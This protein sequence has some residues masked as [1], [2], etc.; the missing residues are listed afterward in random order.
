MYFTAT[1]QQ[2]PAEQIN[3]MSSDSGT[4]RK[5]MSSLSNDINF[6][7]PKEPSN[8]DIK[9]EYNSNKTS[10]VTQPKTPIKPVT[11]TEEEIAKHNREDDCWFILEG[12][13]YDVTTFMDI[14]PGG[15][16][17]L[18]NFAGKDASANIEF[19]SPIMMK[20]AKLFYV[21]NLEGYKQPSSCIIS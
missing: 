10:K 2:V 13:V 6:A 9:K 5:A 3:I 7:I 16:R 14:H 11:Y 1:N 17:A 4:T 18:I 19:H 20:Q 21:G 8:E 12:K 15:K